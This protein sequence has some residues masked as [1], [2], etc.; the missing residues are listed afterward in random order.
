MMCIRRVPTD[1]SRSLSA[2]HLDILHSLLVSR[3]AF[4]ESLVHVQ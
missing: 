4:Y 3:F 1:F 2:N